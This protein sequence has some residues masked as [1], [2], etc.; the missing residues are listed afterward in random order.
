MYH[1]RC[2]RRKSKDR[3]RGAS[4]DGE[5][6]RSEEGTVSNLILDVIARYGGRCGSHSGGMLAVWK[7]MG[8]MSRTADCD[9]GEVGRSMILGYR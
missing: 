4:G 3:I 7:G 1:P 6:T 2:R 5:T 8:G 9:R